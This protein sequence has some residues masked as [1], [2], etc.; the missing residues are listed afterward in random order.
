MSDYEKSSLSA[1]ERGLITGL[2][3]VT[4]IAAFILLVPAVNS[5][6]P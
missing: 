2:S 1:T 5:L 4:A 3:I 6:A